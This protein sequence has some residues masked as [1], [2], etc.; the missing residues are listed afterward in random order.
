M[1][2]LKNLSLACVATLPLSVVVAAT[3][4]AQANCDWYAK[5]AVRQQQINET[6]KCGY[7]GQSWHKD[8]ARHRAWCL[9]V[10]PDLWKAEAKKRS[11]LLMTCEKR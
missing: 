3:A 6:R 1:R 5:T 4:H 10:P 11:D 2:A 9:V 8:L 7:T